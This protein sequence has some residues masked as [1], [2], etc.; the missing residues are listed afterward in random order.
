MATTMTEDQQTVILKLL[1]H[2]LELDFTFYDDEAKEAKEEQLL[3]Y[4]NAAIGMIEREGVTL[5][6]EE[7]DHELLL[8]MYASWLYDK[9][10]NPTVQMPRMVRYNLNNLLFSQKL[11]ESE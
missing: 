4:I 6:L 10:K 2:D 11:E 1:E 8:V 7:F 3:I 5:N 9:R